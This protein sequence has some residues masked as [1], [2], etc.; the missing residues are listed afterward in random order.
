MSL[1]ATIPFEGDLQ[2]Y[3]QFPYEYFFYFFRLG[4]TVVNFI[5][6]T[7]PEEKITIIKFRRTCWANTTADNSVPEDVRQSLHTHTY[8]VGSS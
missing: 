2:E 4:V 6:Q 7:T 8:S 5:L 3:L 1:H